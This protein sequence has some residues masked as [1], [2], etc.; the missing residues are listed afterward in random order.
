MKTRPIFEDAIN[1]RA[2][3]ERAEAR[4]L[5]G[6]PH[7]GSQTCHQKQLQ[8]ICAAAAEVEAGEG[9]EEGGEGGRSGSCSSPVE[10]EV[11][12][13]PLKLGLQL[14]MLLSSRV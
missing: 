13:A 5:F 11:G 7:T 14:K 9:A 3:A 10:V 4:H 1:G 2:A 6:L 8:L 12:D